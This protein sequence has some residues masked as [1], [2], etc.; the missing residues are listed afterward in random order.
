MQQLRDQGSAERARDEMDQHRERD[1]GAKSG[2]LQRLARLVLLLA[3]PNLIHS[4]SAD[5]VGARGSPEKNT[6]CSHF[7]HDTTAR[8][9]PDAMERHGDRDNCAGAPA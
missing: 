3:E 4:S 2:A 6:A 5:G 9:F 1:H 8:S 7:L